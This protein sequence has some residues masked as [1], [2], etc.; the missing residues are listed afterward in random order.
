MVSR[1]SV[2]KINDLGQ[3]IGLSVSI[4]GKFAVITWAA[5]VLMLVMA[6]YWIYETHEDRKVRKKA[7][8]VE[9]KEKIWIHH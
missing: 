4:N 7:G 3:Y 9:L 2:G 5:F 1:K 6:V 8:K